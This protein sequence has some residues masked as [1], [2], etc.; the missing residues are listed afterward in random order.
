MSQFEMKVTPIQSSD[1]HTNVQTY[2][3]TNTQTYKHPNIQTFKP[4]TNQYQQKLNSKQIKKQFPL[5]RKSFEQNFKL[6]LYFQSA[7]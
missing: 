1:K 5:T 2:K 3:H 7:I 4:V 6:L